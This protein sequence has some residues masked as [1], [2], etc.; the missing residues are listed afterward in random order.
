MLNLGQDIWSYCTSY[1]SRLIWADINFF[2]IDNRW[3]YERFMYVL[4]YK[5]RTEGHEIKYELMKLRI[6]S[7]VFTVSSELNFLKSLLP[8]SDAEEFV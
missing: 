7:L 1:M 5:L 2:N 3:K 4:L 8:S 6:Q